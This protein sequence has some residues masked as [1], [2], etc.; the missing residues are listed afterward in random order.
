MAVR[1][2]ESQETWNIKLSKELS[3]QIKD[4]GLQMVI[5]ELIYENCSEDQIHAAMLK[6]MPEYKEDD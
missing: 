2:V 4:K 5:R 6:F 1:I 3:N